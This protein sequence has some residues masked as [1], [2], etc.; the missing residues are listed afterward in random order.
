MAPDKIISLQNISKTY[1]EGDHSRTVLQ[2]CSI[3]FAPG[4]VTAILGKS[5]SGKTTLLNIISGIDRSDTGQIFYKDTNL[6][7]MDDIQRTLFRRKN[8]GFVFQFYNLIPTMSVW[9]NVIFPLELNKYTEAK[10]CQYA[11]EL[12][13]RVG[14]ADR[15][16][17]YPEQLSGGEMQRI[18]I[19]RAM[20]H[21]P[22]LL[23]ADEPTGN[24]DEETGKEVL[25]LLL[26]LTRSENRNLILVTHSPMAAKIADRILYLNHGSLSQTEIIPVE[27]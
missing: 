12:L 15:M 27:L 18:S 7:E 22:L 24:L 4:E 19:V 21:H 2:N 17:D 10:H 6:S 25:I 8:I 9:E 1:R 23:L 14:L 20:V 13:E 26:E 16:K 11:L 3:D 5:G